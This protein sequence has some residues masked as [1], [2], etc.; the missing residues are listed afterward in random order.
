MVSTPND[1]VKISEIRFVLLIVIDFKHAVPFIT[2]PSGIRTLI[3]R[4][5]KSAG[6][7][8]AVNSVC[9]NVRSAVFFAF[10]LRTLLSTSRET[11]YRATGLTN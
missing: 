5:A 10:R 9:V 7:L 2:K 4:Q 1:A 3:L 6:R 8:H 11:N